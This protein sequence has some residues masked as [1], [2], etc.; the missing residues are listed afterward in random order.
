[1]SDKEDINQI[2]ERHDIDIKSI[3][4]AFHKDEQGDPDYISHRMFHRAQAEDD[5]E[6]RNRKSEI[7]A[8]IVTWAVIGLITLLA[9]N[10]LQYLPKILE[11]GK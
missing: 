2:L 8:N 5:Y 6:T 10:F 9:S 4:A 11:V 1:M 3:K 7:M